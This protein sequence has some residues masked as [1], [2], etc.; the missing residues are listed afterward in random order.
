MSVEQT[1]AV[2]RKYLGTG[3]MDSSARLCMADAVRLYDEGQLDEA[4]AR[5][6]ASLRYSIGILHPDYRKAQDFIAVPACADCGAAAGE[7]CAPYCHTQTDYDECPRTF[8]IYRPGEPMEGV[9]HSFS[10]TG[11]IPMTGS[12]RCMLCGQIKD[13]IQ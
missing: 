9:S 12:L 4:R 13:K 6:L 3:V 7:R 5:A 1:M 2:A 10:W 11:S 8:A